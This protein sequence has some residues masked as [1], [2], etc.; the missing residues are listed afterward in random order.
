MLRRLDEGVGAATAAGD[1]TAPV[2]E[3]FTALA[4]VAFAASGLRGAATDTVQLLVAL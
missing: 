3:D 1:F 4:S 2:S